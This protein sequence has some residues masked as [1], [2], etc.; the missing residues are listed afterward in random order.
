MP[1][2]ATGA[3]VVITGRVADP[4]LFL[5][6]HAARIRL[7]GSTIVDRIARGTVIGHLLECAG[8]VTGGYFA[9]PGRKDVPDLAH[10]G[11]PCADVDAD[12]NATLGKVGRHRRRITCYCEGAAALRGHRS[13]AAM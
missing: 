7:G 3:D 6:P 8:Q 2:L 1:A 11:F 4:S 13:A 5:A 12:G 10:L 9:D